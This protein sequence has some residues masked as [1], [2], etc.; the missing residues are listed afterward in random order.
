MNVCCFSWA[1]MKVTEYAVSL[2]IILCFATL[3]KQSFAEIGK[4][5]QILSSEAQQMQTLHLFEHESKTV[6]PLRPTIKFIPCVSPFSASDTSQANKYTLSEEME[7]GAPA[8]T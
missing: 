4:L 2:W 6:S 5:T 1:G 3:R 8:V 7:E